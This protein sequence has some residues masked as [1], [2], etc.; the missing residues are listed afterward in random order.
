MQ[1]SRNFDVALAVA[2]SLLLPAVVLLLGDPIY[3]GIWYYFVVPAVALGLGAAF[4]VKPLF[5]SGVSLAVTVTLLIY[6]SINWSAERP[7]GLLGLG[8]LFSLP[9]AGIGV[10]LGAVLSKQTEYP[11]AG[12]L[13]GLLGLLSGFLV[14]QIVVCNTLMWCGPL[15]MKILR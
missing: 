6:M 12:L 15:S 10:M 9:G 11:L 7:E 3:I 8:H 2:I 1:L 5:L 14:N 13:S 4:R